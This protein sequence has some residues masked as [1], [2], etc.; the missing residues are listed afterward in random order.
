MIRAERVVAGLAEV[1]TLAVGSIPRVGPA[2][3]ELG[4]IDRGAVAIDRGRF[5]WVGPERRLRSEVRLRAGGRTIDGG[6]GTAVPGFV[7]AH[8][9]VLFAGERSG[10]LA[11]KAEGATYGEI[12]RRGGGL[13]S[14]VR[15]TRAASATRLLAE[16]GA[17][18]RRMAAAGTTSVE[19]KSGY[20]LNHDGELRLLRLIPRLARATGLRLVPTYLGAHAVAPEL[21]ERADVY[22]DRIVRRTVPAVARGGWA[23][24]CDVFCEPG[25]FSV[26]QAERILRAARSFGL[27]LKLHADEFVASG[28][29]R[30]AARLG[31]RSADHLLATSA[32]DR[33]RLGRAGVSAVVLP[34][35]ALASA[36]SRRSPAREL[37]D[38]GA[39]VALGTDCSPNTWV[40]EMPTVL[41][42]AVHA[43]RL[44]PAEALTAATVNA[45]HAIGLESAGTIQLGR[46][47]DL[48]VLPVASASSIGYRFTLRPT[49][50]LREGKPVSPP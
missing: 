16:T 31:T 24:F 38:A 27:G 11:W 48:V 25:F 18:L 37:V 22:V 43:G 42:A 30:L 4:V 47:A 8:T 14:T 26:A 5:V 29:A 2:M 17:R 45:A 6:G 35:T 49:V 33:R 40:E 44:T 23:R 20:A 9:H 34:L 12:A 13:F 3:R 39:P 15:A 19:V 41:A 7:D 46:P 32:A 28:G 36:A 10:E 50:V 21:S 1:A